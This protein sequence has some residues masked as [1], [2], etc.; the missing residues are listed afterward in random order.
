MKWLT[1]KH[2]SRRFIYNKLH[3]GSEFHVSWNNT[4]RINCEFVLA[5]GVTI[6]Q[7]TFDGQILLHLDGAKATAAV[8][9]D[10][11]TVAQLDLDF[12]YSKCA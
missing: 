4:V 11:L 5:M 3:L 2:I 8:Q 9:E 10:S 1:V 6:E 7:Q 12:C